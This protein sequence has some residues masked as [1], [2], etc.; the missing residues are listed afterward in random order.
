[1]LKVASS[2]YLTA[3][4]NPVTLGFYFHVSSVSYIFSFFL[5]K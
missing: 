4:M 5:W 1:M 2:L 3:E